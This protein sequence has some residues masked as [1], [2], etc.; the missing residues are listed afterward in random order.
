MKLRRGEMPGMTWMLG[1]VDEAVQRAGLKVSTELMLFRKALL[2]L[3]GLTAELSGGDVR[4]DDVLLVSFVERFCAEWPRRFS[5]GLTTKPRTRLS[6]VDLM[7]LLLSAPTA[8]ARW[9]L[10][11]LSTGSSRIPTV[12]SKLGTPT[13]V[14]VP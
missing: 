8:A 13:A 11:E 9:L 6:N 3:E 1:L 5:A 14:G 10:A 4:I 2:I 12:R 7:R